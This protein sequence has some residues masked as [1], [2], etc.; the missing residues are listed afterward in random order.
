MR[1]AGRYLP[2]FRK[3]REQH[4][5]FTIC[6]TPKLACEITLQPIARFDLDAAI[7]FSDILVVP[8]ALGMEVLMQ[9]GVVSTYRKVAS[10]SLSLLVAHFQKTYEKEI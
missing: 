8:Q 7:I 1:Q 9:P 10:S 2:E 6:Q 3:V 5:F 4:D